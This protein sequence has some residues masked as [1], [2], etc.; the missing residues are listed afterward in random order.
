M[1]SSV[2]DSII[3]QKPTVDLLSRIASASHQSISHQAEGGGK[4]DL[5]Q[6]WLILVAPKSPGLSPPP[7][8]V[9]KAVAAN[10]RPACRS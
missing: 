5:S 9:R 2:W 10:A 1:A 8:N 7:W 4:K 6:S 3:G